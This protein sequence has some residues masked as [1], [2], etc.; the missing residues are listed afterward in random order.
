M[1]IFDDLKS[2]LGKGYEAT[3]QKSKKL[4]DISRLTL[5]VRGK[6]EYEN[7]LHM[8]LGQSL[9]DRWDSHG[10]LEMTD[11]TRSLLYNIKDL[12]EVIQSMEDQLTELRKEEEQTISSHPTLNRTA[13]PSPQ[14]SQTISYS[15]RH[16]IPLPENDE[17]LQDSR[18]TNDTEE[19][20][21]IQ[22]HL[23]GVQNEN[24]PAQ[25]NKA[26]NQEPSSTSWESWEGQGIFLCPHCGKEV[27]DTEQRCLHCQGEIYS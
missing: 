19:V 18:R 8:R 2:K 7:E 27:K 16:T 12:R 14:T 26:W 24:V 22:S 3:S 15:E 5:Q 11:R 4:L 9:Y 10:N 23:H 25:T 17:K 21:A 6:K 1:G 13:T 20:T